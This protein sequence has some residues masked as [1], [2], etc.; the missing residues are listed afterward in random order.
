MIT[1]WIGSLLFAVVAILYLLLAM[2]FPYG[3]YAMGGQQK[4]IV[5]EKRPV[6]IVSF[7]IQL[8]AILVLLQVGSVFSIG[9]PQTVARGICYFF[10]GYLLLNTFMNARSKSRKERMV[11]TPLSL[12]IALCFL[13]TALNA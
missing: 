10:T 11:M 13:F 5:K 7:V 1:A 2:G 3:E 12:I 6:Y 4:V 9:L 8:F